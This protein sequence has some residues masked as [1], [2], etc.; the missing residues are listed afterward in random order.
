[1][2]PI[3]A[4]VLFLKTANP[5]HVDLPPGATHAYEVRL[6]RGESAEVIVEQKGVDVVV[7]L[8]APNGTLLDEVDAPTG[9]NGEE[10]VE[11]LA[12]E[13]GR[14]GIVVRPYAANEPAGAY[15]ID[16]RELRGVAATRALL[17]SRQDARDRAAEWLRAR[18]G[19]QAFDDLA[20]R[21]RV[22]ALGEATHGSRELGDIR[23][24]LT[25]RLIE[26]HGYRVVALEA[27]A[28][29]SDSMWIG[30]RARRELVEWVGEW[31]RTHPNDRVRVVGVDAQENGLARDTLHAFLERAYGEEL[32]P[33]WLA[34][35]KELAAADEQSAVFGDS[36]VSVETRQ[37]LFDIAARMSLDAA[38][39]H[40][41]FSGAAD[42]AA[43][44]IRTLAAFADYNSSAPG[45]HS[46]DS[47]M[48]DGVVRAIEDGGRAV[49]WA[50]NAHVA[51]RARTAGALLRELLGCDYAAVAL[52]FGEGAFL[53]QIPNDPD[54]RLAVSSL[55]PAAPE[56]IESAFGAARAIATWP[57]A[58]DRATAPEWLRVPHPMHW[59]GALWSPSSHPSA[60]YR[61]FDL[62]HDF[63]G[64]VYVPRATAEDA[65][66]ERA[67]IAPRR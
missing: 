56:S 30:R 49:F 60:G 33:R 46:R 5:Q 21:A 35:E 52:T 9:R 20:T 3:L 50:H 67:H 63:D 29:L 22:V 36:S 14:Y 44:A 34:A 12:T 18:S 48:A 64:I 62:L 19:P 37:T 41:R 58:V 4:A 23:L 38:T 54:D 16:V 13:T 51:V 11:I 39:L 47:Y 7:E 24:E 53:A 1:V 45:A 31:N 28:T 43:T 42:D 57:C 65:P 61:P 17:Q 26:Q 59:V 8:H 15:V 10:R 66:R 25:R 27:G 2:H 40:A 6:K 55:P 32:M